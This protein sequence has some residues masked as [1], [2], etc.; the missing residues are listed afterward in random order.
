MR[1]GSC[2]RSRRGRPDPARGQ[3]GCRGRPPGG[4]RRHEHHLR[5]DR[6]REARRAGV[7]HRRR[8]RDRGTR[9]A[10]LHAD[11]PTTGE[12]TPPTSPGPLGPASASASFRASC[13]EAATSPPIRMA[14]ADSADRA[15]GA[16]LRALPSMNRLAKTLTARAATRTDGTRAPSCASATSDAGVATAHA[17]TTTLSSVGSDDARSVHRADPCDWIAPARRTLPREDVGR[18]DAR[19]AHAR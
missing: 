7:G 12:S 17:L 16:L 1:A 5:R 4:D 19:E 11:V 3:R 15:A 2:S 10:R 6:R 13:A 9:D 18:R 14:P 8:D